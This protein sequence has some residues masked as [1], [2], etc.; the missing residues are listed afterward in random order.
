MFRFRISAN[1][2]YRT[3]EAQ[4]VY[5]CEDGNILINQ[6]SAQGETCHISKQLDRRQEGGAI[7]IRYPFS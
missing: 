2:A 1:L 4:L 6:A 3:L 5:S 7:H